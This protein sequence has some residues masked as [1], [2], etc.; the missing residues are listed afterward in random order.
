MLSL[1]MNY[2]EKTFPK[3]LAITKKVIRQIA[4]ASLMTFGKANRYKTI[5]KM[6]QE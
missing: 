2:E 3:Q 6:E 4:K 5:T 1:K